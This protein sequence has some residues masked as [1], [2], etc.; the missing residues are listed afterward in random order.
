[1]YNF[2]SP[3]EVLAKGGGKEELPRGEGLAVKVKP[4]RLENAL[5]SVRP[6]LGGGVVLAR[7]LDSH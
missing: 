2:S 5:G 7:A 1:M 3:T 6:C 4:T